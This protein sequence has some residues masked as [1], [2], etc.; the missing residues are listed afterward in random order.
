MRGSEVFADPQ[1]IPWRPASCASLP[2]ALVANDQKE[3]FALTRTLCWAVS[4]RSSPKRSCRALRSAL[5]VFALRH[6][7]AHA[8]KTSCR[9]ALSTKRSEQKNT[10]DFSA[11]GLCLARDDEECSPPCILVSGSVI[12]E[13]YWRWFLTK[14][15]RIS[16]PLHAR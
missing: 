7:A 8:E 11:R 5:Q 4:S 3:S 1:T 6:W 15:S 14:Q 10:L 9:T 13:R 12:D 16:L 2:S